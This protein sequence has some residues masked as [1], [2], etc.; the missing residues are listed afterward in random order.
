MDF[1][2]A[3]NNLTN[4]LIDLMAKFKMGAVGPVGK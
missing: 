2:C 3:S 4:I 1:F